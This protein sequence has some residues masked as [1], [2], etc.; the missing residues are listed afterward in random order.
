MKCQLGSCSTLILD[1]G[2]TWRPKPQPKEASFEAM[3]AALEAGCNFW[4]AGEFCGTPEYNSLTLLEE[5]FTRYPEDAE[6]VVL[7]I[8]GGLVNMAPDGTP[9]GVRMSMDNC[10]RLLNGRKHID[11]FECARVDKNVPIETT[12][13]TLE[14]EYVKSGKLGGIALSEVSA[15]TIEKAVKATKIVAVEVELSL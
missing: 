4:N 6:K 9:E 15:A 10:L 12:L 1:K 7:S 13:K 5:Y 8:K 2:L 3:K 11:I 14:E